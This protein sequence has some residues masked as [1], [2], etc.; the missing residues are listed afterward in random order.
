[1]KSKAKQLQFGTIDP[2]FAVAGAPL[3]EQAQGDSKPAP[4]PAEPDSLTEIFGPVIHAYTRAQ[5]IEDGELMDVSE[6][7]KEA[8]I[9]FP[10]ALTRAVW[11]SYVAVPP[12]V[13]GQDEKGRLWDTVWMLRA[14]IAGS[15]GKECIHYQLYVR[16]DNRRA[17][18]V[19]LKAICGPGDQGEPVVT[20]LLPEE[21]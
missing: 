9:K 20:I 3:F 6:I 16:N 4:S 5:A 12:G 8:G 1:M 10:V 2:D 15:G 18:K 19:T 14:A 13:S 11:A 21:D 17:R 7:A